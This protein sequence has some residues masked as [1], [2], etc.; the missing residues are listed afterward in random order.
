LTV[1]EKMFKFL[2]VKD[3]E[4]EY[5]KITLDEIVDKMKAKEYKRI[6]VLTGAGLSVAAGI[7][8][9]RSPGTGLYSKLE[10][11]KLPYPEA[12]FEINYYKKN[13]EAFLTLSKEL[14]TE[15]YEPTL[16]HAFIKKLNDE[17]MLYMNMTQNIDD[18]ELKA[19]L[20]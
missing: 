6:V 5:K 7:P 10:K 20:P 17:G 18:L 13:P 11:Y 3:K 9:F 8:D 15:N 14:L 19:G 16:G 4:P 2:N 12:I 1:L